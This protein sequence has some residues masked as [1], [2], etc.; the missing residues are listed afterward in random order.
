M[1]RRDVNDSVS[2]VSRAFGDGVPMTI[3]CECGRPSCDERVRIMRADFEAA[4][5]A[6]RYV[7]AL[8]HSSGGLVRVEHRSRA[9]APYL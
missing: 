3:V 2:S 4:R 8:G 1:L 7:V 5:A 6:G 9:E